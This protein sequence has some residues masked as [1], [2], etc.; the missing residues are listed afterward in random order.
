MSI[1]PTNY[2][3]DE[4]AAE[5]AEVERDMRRRLTDR[6]DMCAKFDEE[7]VDRDIFGLGRTVGRKPS[8]A[9]ERELTIELNSIGQLLRERAREECPNAAWEGLYDAANLISNRIGR[10]GLPQLMHH[11]YL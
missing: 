11:D 4:A 7:I 6:M 10:C 5:L 3:P 1:E 9:S 8:T 2:R